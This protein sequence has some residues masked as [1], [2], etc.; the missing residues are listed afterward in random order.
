MF[1]IA[2]MPPAFPCSEAYQNV[3]AGR[4]GLAPQSVGIPAALVE[5]QARALN[6][7]LVGAS[8][9][10][11]I[12]AAQEAVCPGRLAIVSSFGTESAVLLAAA[13]AVDRS[14]PVLIIDTD[15]LFPETLAYRDQLQRLLGLRDVHAIRPDGAELAEEDVDGDLYARDPDACCA[16]R[17]VRPLAKALRGVDA[18]VNGRKRFQGGD[19]SVIPVVEAEGPRLKF[20]PLAALSPANIAARFADAGLPPHPLEKHGFRSIGCMPCTSAT[21]PGEDPRA[22]RWRGRGKVECGIHLGAALKG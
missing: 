2:S 21:R 8:P 14:V 10:E 5:L 1:E 12:A 9:E 19:R 15:Y 6:V 20:N 18:W 13:A 17:K 22:G 11:I 3:S 4:V 16:L 7:L